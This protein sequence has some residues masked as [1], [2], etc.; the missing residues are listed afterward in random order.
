[1]KDIFIGLLA[2]IGVVFGVVLIIGLLLWAV[3]GFGWLVGWVLHLMVGPNIVFGMTFEQ[4][5]GLLFIAGTIVGG[6]RSAI[7]KE[8]K[9][10]I[11]TLTNKIKSYRGY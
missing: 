1:M 3:Y 8:T 11:E 4:F 10:N 5:V 9:K 6:S 7:D 2:I